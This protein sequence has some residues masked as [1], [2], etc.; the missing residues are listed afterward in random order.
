VLLK[1]GDR[2]EDESS[3]DESAEDVSLDDG[4]VQPGSFEV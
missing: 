4:L 1:P 2:P 3:G